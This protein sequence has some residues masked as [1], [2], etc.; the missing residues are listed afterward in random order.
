MQVEKYFDVKV[1][2]YETNSARKKGEVKKTYYIP[3]LMTPYL[4]VIEKAKSIKAGV[5]DENGN[6]RT[7]AVAAAERKQIMDK[8]FTEVQN[9]ALDN[10]RQSLGYEGVLV[11][12]TPKLSK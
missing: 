2:F 6:K 1:E 7:S 10:V 11:A 3:V 5:K 12:Y 9:T 8:V 4:P